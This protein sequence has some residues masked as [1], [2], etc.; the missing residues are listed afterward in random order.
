MKP[1]GVITD[2]RTHVTGVTSADLE[3]VTC[4]L[5]AAQAAMLACLAKQESGRQVI[6]TFQSQVHVSFVLSA[7]IKGGPCCHGALT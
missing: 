3:G 5:A 1:A 6:P 2:L 4:D 7:N